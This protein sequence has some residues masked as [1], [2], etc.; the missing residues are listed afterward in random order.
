MT[1]DNNSILGKGLSA[2]MP[3]EAKIG[4]NEV[5]SVQIAKYET[6]LYDR[7]E[8]LSK[9]ITDIQKD[10][11]MHNAVALQ[12]VDFSKYDG[13]TMA[14][15]GLIT[16]LKDNPTL[17]WEDGEI[18][19]VVKMEHTDKGHRTSTDFRKSFSIPINKQH[20]AAREKMLATL[21][22][23]T[24]A[25]KGVIAGISNMSRKERQ[26]KARISEI[27]L[28]EQGIDLAADPELAALVKID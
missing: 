17:S 2:I 21:Q 23:T 26:V 1:D 24:E 18:H 27:R 4:M 5:V 22:E 9:T 14:K 11:E 3:A 13:V 20:I 6:G 16:K 10:L 19:Q 7:K 12:G 28:K 15:L 8:E 25:L